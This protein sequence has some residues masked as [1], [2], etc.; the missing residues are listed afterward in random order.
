MSDKPD[1]SKTQPELDPIKYK[2]TKARPRKGQQ[3]VTE[4]KLKGAPAFPYSDELA[5]EICLKVATSTKGLN[6]L[7]K[8]HS[9]WPG[10]TTIY[11]W[12]IKFPSFAE[13]YLQAK[14]HQADLLAEE[15]LD[16]A[17]DN[18]QDEYIDENGN[19]RLNAEFVSRSKLR[20]ETRKWMAGRLLPKVWGDKVGQDEDRRLESLVER[21]IDKLAEK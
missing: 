18:S 1:Q 11:E 7:C 8:E 2:I 4:E 13:K 3:A 14:R 6:H 20:V 19:R 21:M 10:K 12:R 16:I 17:D 9:H 5:E 15:T